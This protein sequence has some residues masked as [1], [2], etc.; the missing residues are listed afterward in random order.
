M[1]LLLTVNITPTTPTIEMKRNYII[2]KIKFSSVTGRTGKRREQMII[3][4]LTDCVFQD[5][6]KDSLTYYLADELLE[7]GYMIES[8]KLRK[9]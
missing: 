4:E 3:D 6:S 9:V 1:A 5:T 2:T 8:I 7:K